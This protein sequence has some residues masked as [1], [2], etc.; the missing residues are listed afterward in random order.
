M[1]NK[2]PDE[3]WADITFSR[4]FLTNVLDK[5]KSIRDK[6]TE[7]EFSS[8]D[9]IN[10]HMGGVPV[11]FKLADNYIRIDIG[12]NNQNQ[13]FVTLYIPDKWVTTP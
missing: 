8:S 12:E 7:F 3:Q 11:F 13:P 9:G 4:G 6:M 5:V 10:T 1:P 2:T